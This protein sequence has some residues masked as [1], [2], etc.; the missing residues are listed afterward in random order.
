ML[1]GG[2]RGRAKGRVGKGATHMGPVLL[3]GLTAQDGGWRDGRFSVV[4]LHN[5]RGTVLFGLLG[6][7][8]VRPAHETRVYVEISNAYADLAT[9]DMIS[10]GPTGGYA[11]YIYRE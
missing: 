3:R 1:G 7:W 2:A 4:L 5:D 10:D 11:G 9:H 8:A 6:V